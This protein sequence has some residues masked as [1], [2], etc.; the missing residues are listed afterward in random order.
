MICYS[1]FNLLDIVV[2]CS[3][4]L[5]FVVMVSLARRLGY[6]VSDAKDWLFDVTTPT[7]YVVFVL[8]LGVGALM[9]KVLGFGYIALVIVV[10]AAL[11]NA[12][13]L[14]HYVKERK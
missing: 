2:A 12:A 1:F 4:V 7:R 10:L 3:L 8:V 14:Y 11:C 6:N 5:S 9:L 13:L